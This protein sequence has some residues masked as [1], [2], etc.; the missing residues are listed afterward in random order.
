MDRLAAY[1]HWKDRQCYEQATW[2]AQNHPINWKE[3]ENWAVLEGMD[4]HT[5]LQFYNSAKP[6]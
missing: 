4:E 2:V 5:W 6:L 3:V 1:L